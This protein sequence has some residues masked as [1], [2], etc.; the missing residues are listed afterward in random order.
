MYDELCPI[1]RTEKVSIEKSPDGMSTYHCGHKFKNNTGLKIKNFGLFCKFCNNKDHNTL[2]LT[3][4]KESKQ[5]RIEGHMY[6]SSVIF[7][8][9]CDKCNHLSSV[10]ANTVPYIYPP[11]QEVLTYNNDSEID[12][13]NKAT[14]L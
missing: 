10:R 1:C 5:G 7:V 6:T 2:H 14:S 12:E 4:A 9:S 13:S 3:S 11:L 8:V